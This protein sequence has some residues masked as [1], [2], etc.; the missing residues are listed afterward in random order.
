MHRNIK[1]KHNHSHV[2]YDDEAS[3]NHLLHLRP[4]SFVWDL[5]R[6]E[7]RGLW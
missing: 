1:P 3:A 7:I 4:W 5:C 6:H 2:T